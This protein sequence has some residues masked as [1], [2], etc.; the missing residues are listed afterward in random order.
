MAALHDGV[1]GDTGDVR[2]VTLVGL[3]SGGSAA[4]TTI[5]GHFKRGA[6]LVTVTGTDNTDDATLEQVDI[7][8]GTFLAHADCVVGTWQ[9]EVEL[10]SGLPGELTFPQAGPSSIKVRGQLG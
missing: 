1:I 8:V 2:V 3:A 6:L 9:F 5:Q 4:A 7:P 10:D